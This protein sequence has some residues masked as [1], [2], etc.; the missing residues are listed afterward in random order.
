ML[1]TFGDIHD[2]RLTMKGGPAWNRLAAS[3]GIGFAV[4]VIATGVIGEAKDIA[5]AGDVY[6]ASNEVFG[7]ITMLTGVAAVM[8]FW[9]TGTLAARVRQ[10]EGGSGRLAAVV[11]GSGAFISG[12]LAL[13]IAGVFAARN[14]G[15]PELAAFTTGLLDGPTLFFPAAAYVT[16]AGVVGM[17]AEGL[18]TYSQWLAR[19]SIPLGATYIALA[20]LQIFKY[21]AWIN[22]TG[23]ISFAVWVI[24]LSAIGISRWGD[25]DERAI[26]I[27][28]VA[29]ARRAPAPA[30]ETV[31]LD[32]DE[33]EVPRP[34]AR[35]PAARKTTT[36]KTTGKAPA[37]KR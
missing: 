24:A 32:E 7:S 9:F 22:E 26:G 4:A 5:F 25:M 2:R 13:G 8:L 6:T 12:S 19:I 30:P 35:K 18:P 3:T 1:Q 37:H 20:G 23:Y 17:R 21:Y 10:L 28:P 14:G 16:A 15:A 11:N 33:D 36:R 29:P 31:E 34:R 27:A